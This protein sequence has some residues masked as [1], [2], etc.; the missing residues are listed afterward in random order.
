M[1]IPAEVSDWIGD[2]QG[3]HPSRSYKWISRAA[4]EQRA[5]FERCLRDR[6]FPSGATEDGYATCVMLLERA[7]DTAKIRLT[8][9]EREFD[10]KVEERSYLQDRAM[11]DA[12]A[13]YPY[14]RR[15][16]VFPNL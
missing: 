10:R 12:G 13:K 11:K 3:E 14:Y 5:L 9:W 6:R 16:L 2:W 4:V 7:A 8:E 1:Y 15:K